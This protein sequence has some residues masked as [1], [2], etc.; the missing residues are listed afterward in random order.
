MKPAVPSVGVEPFVFMEWPTKGCMCWKLILNAFFAGLARAGG[1]GVPHF[2]WTSLRLLP[3]KAQSSLLRA[4]LV[5]IKPKHLQT[6][7]WLTLPPFWATNFKCL[8]M[9]LHLIF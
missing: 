6:F 9:C 8:I 4:Q 1:G 2:W 3:M 7:F 5:L